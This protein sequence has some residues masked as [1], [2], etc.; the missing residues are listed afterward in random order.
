MPWKKNS[1]RFLLSNP[2]GVRDVD[3]PYWTRTPF[4]SQQNMDLLP[5]KNGRNKIVQYGGVLHIF[6]IWHL[7]PIYKS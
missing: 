7:V 1:F 3:K 2:I 4:I 6:G 5:K